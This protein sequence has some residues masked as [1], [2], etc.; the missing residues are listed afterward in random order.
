MQFSLGAM[1]ALVTVLCAALGL[2]VSPAEG[3]R[4]A[5][6]AT[7]A[8]GGRVEYATSDAT[9][10]QGRSSALLRRW[11]SRD[12]FDAV[13]EIELRSSRITDE[14][15][16]DFHWLKGLRLLS[17]TNSP[18]TD[19]GLSH[20]QGLTSLRELEL[21]Y[22]LITDAGL[23]RL[24]RLKNLRALSLCGDRITDAGMPHLNELTGLEMLC[25]D[26]TQLS[27]DGLSRLVGLGG[28]RELRLDY[29]PVTGAGRRICKAC[30][31]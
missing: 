18:I 14:T 12:Y 7:K 29:T 21:D 17:I 28:L 2:W 13:E 1:F 16:V 25:L 3:Q 30:V 6:A 10:K 24:R 26:A 31:R 4:R 8:A 22:T 11:L 20:L 15:L 27:D 9:A 19:L 23:A 5:V